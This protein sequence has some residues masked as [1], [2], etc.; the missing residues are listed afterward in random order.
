MEETKESLASL[1]ES[2]GFQVLKIF[3]SRKNT[4][5]LIKI[6]GA[7][8][9]LKLYAPG[10]VE[11]LSKEYH[12]LEEGHDMGLN[13]PEPYDKLERAIIMEYIEG[14]NLMDAI[15]DTSVPM[16]QKKAQ[17]G[18]LVGWLSSFHKAFRKGNQFLLRGDANLRN[19]ILTWE[20]W[21]LDFEEAEMG[22]PEQDLGNLCC[23]ILASDPMFV[24]WKVELCNLLVE[25]YSSR[26]EWS[27]EDIPSYIAGILEEKANL[28]PRDAELLR[29][30][31]AIIAEKGL[32]AIM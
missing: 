19:F 25:S 14:E 4:V 7:N 20:I 11:N 28:R 9:V 29:E 13:V 10:Q 2:K 1:S 18:L 12:I 24:P 30:K 23:S 16:S 15:N 3:E 26:V 31:A 27:V 8:R 32:D 6:R 5:V 21:G 17:I 22:R